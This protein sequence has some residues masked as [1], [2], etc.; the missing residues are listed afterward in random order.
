MTQFQPPTPGPAM[1][2]G[3]PV[4]VP[5]AFNEPVRW[6]AAAVAGFV[7]SLVGCL[8]VTAP[9]GLILGIVGIVTTRGGRRRGMG[10]AIAAIPIS[11][12]TGVFS[13]IV[14]ANVVVFGQV[15][16]QAKEQ[17]PQLLK[18]DAAST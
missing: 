18:L 16:F 15:L 4:G 6:S 12:L 11:L 2:P 17:L 8:I 5:P 14:V 13:L 7:L 10:L 3:G 1:A 9:L